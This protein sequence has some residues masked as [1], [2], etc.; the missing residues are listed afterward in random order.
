M[1]ADEQDREGRLDDKSPAEVETVSTILVEVRDTAGTAPKE[2]VEE[3]LRSRLDRS[4]VN[5]PENEIADLVTQV[6]EG[7][8]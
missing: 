8:D 7:T 1:N 4:G 2:Q 6:V 3:M 5:L